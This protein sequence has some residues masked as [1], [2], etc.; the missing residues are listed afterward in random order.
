MNQFI[1]AVVAAS[2][3]V[4]SNSA[5]R[6]SNLV[7]SRLP[8]NPVFPQIREPFS[9]DAPPFALLATSSRPLLFRNDRKPL[10]Q[11]PQIIKPH[12]HFGSALLLL[13]SSPPPS[14]P[15]AVREELNRRNGDIF[16]EITPQQHH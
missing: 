15:V 7:R 5:C 16:A 2:L 14:L 4:A 9:A 10:S 1:A 6:E 3:S 8:V 13:Y 11:F 12:P